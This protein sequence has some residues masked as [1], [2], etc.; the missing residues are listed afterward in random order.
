MSIYSSMNINLDYHPVSLGVRT[1]ILW[2]L[3]LG[4]ATTSSPAVTHQGPTYT[5]ADLL[6]YDNLS[7]FLSY[8]PIKYNC[9]YFELFKQI[10]L[11][12][13]LWKLLLMDFPGSTVYKN[14]ASQGRGHR[15]NP[16]SGKIPHAAEQLKLVCQNHW[17]QGLEPVSRNYRSLHTL[18]PA[19][20]NKRSHHNEISPCSP[21]LEEACAHNKDPVQ[22]K[23]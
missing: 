5:K 21:R 19:C 15:F 10:E 1:T 20:H 7:F 18:G 9:Y 17:D 6:G 4:P 12:L 13:L 23:T 22:P 3:S 2:F 11:N 16:G 14:S 8:V